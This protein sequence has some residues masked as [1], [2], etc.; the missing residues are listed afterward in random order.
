MLR[1]KQKVLKGKRERESTTPNE[2]IYKQKMKLQSEF[3]LYCYSCY[4]CDYVM[5]CYVMELLCYGK[6]KHNNNTGG[7]ILF[8][9][10]LLKQSE[11]EKNLKKLRISEFFE[12]LRYFEKSQ[13]EVRYFQK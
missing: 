7:G 2:I 9:Y 6:L 5:F 4:A 11:S 3:I 10:F 12:N 13:Y 8:E 1:T